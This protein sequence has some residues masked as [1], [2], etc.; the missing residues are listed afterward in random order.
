M[1]VAAAVTYAVAAV[2]DSGGCGTAEGGSLTNEAQWRPRAGGG[3]RSRFF[4]SEAGGPAGLAV[5]EHEGAFGVGEEAGEVGFLGGWCRGRSR[6]GW[7]G[8]EGGAGAAAEVVDSEAWVSE[9]DGGAQPGRAARR[10]RRSARGGG[11]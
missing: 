11:S 6:G 10:V 8:A 7:G 9:S 2:T 1:R 4:Y 3:P 5:Q